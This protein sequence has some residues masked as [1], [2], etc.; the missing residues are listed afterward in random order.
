MLP[1][2]PGEEVLSHEGRIWKMAAITKLAAE[3]LMAVAE[4][5]R[6]PALAEIVDI[7][8]ADFPE[9][10]VSHPQY[11]RRKIERKKFLAQNAANAE[12]RRHVAAL[13]GQAR[14]P[15]ITAI[16]NAF[17]LPGGG[18]ADATAYLR[19]QILYRIAEMRAAP[20]ALNSN[21]GL[22]TNFVTLLA[23]AALA[24]PNE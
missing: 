8:L 9:H 4:T 1:E 14:G 10:H 7:D 15:R 2:F 3:D 18:W 5:G 19:G 16:I 12:R 23:M 22:Y 20:I 11:E 17:R 21:L 6:P 13:R 24:P